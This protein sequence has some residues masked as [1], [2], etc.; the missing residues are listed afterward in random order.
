VHA[1]D[2]HPHHASTP[3]NGPQISL[4]ATPAGLLRLLSDVRKSTVSALLMFL[5]HGDVTVIDNSVRVEVEGWGRD[6]L[7]EQGFKS[8]QAQDAIA[9]LRERGWIRTE[10]LRRP[11]GWLG[12][13]IGVLAG[14]VYGSGEVVLAPERK[15]PT[16][17]APLTELVLHTGTTGEGKT[18]SNTA[19]TG[20]GIPGKEPTPPELI[21]P[22]SPLDGFPGKGTHKPDN[23][24][25]NTGEGK[26]LTGETLQQPVLVSSKQYLQS[27]IN[28]PTINSKQFYAA[29]H[30]TGAAINNNPHRAS[31][32]FTG[33]LRG[34]KLDYYLPLTDLVALPPSKDAARD[35][36]DYLT[37]VLMDPDTA[38]LSIPHL[39]R[40]AD[41]HIKNEDDTWLSTRWFLALISAASHNVK[42]VP[43]YV[44]AAMYREEW[45]NSPS[46]KDLITTLLAITSNP[47]DITEPNLD[48]HLQ[49]HLDQILTLLGD[50]FDAPE[51]QIHIWR[52]NH[53][54][55]GQVITR[56]TTENGGMT[57][58]DVL[59]ENYTPP[60][61][62]TVMDSPE[63]SQNKESFP[64]SPAPMW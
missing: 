33:Y 21:V 25:Y 43:A 2:I 59:R 15:N 42:S 13:Q 63:K 31:K 48:T 64:H 16:R 38:R 49:A 10:Q 41:I 19:I 34:Y 24:S 53:R 52:V 35:I 23:P 46:I 18:L 45:K 7:K 56:F 37:S 14:S 11:G 40:A 29:L 57:P 3:R 20:E 28:Q 26:T 4:Q 30:A 36:A 17:K 1:L 39:A 47:T 22:L 9:E 50:Y 58:E 55:R 60:G 51:N 32:L 5:E 62:A 61:G 6:W 8:N 27:L 44:H 12:R 54:L